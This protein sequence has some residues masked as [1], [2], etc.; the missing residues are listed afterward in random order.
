MF[1]L[2]INNLIIMAETT[3]TNLNNLLKGKYLDS[4]DLME[5]N[6]FFFGS[7]E[8]I[9][10][11]VTPWSDEVYLPYTFTEGFSSA[12]EEAD[13]IEASTFDMWKMK[14]KPVKLYSKVFIKDYDKQ[15]LEKW[16]DAL[17]TWLIK[18]LFN[19]LLRAPKE[20]FL[21]LLFGRVDWAFG[22]VKTDATW[23]KVIE[24]N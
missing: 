15:I 21:R 12:I 10:P 6:D 5:K 19:S 1:Y 8:R 22:T 9:V 3:I 11:K 4:I 7:L 20:E 13:D 2:F 16:E 17:K 23:T 14:I 18:W 24:V